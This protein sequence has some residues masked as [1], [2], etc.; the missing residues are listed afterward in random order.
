LFFALSLL[1]K[2]AAIIL[3][4]VLFLMDYW[5]D[6]KLSWKTFFEKIPF[7]VAA[8][9]FAFITLKIQTP[10]AV[11]GTDQYPLWTRPLFASYTMMIYFIRFF[12]PYPLAAFH[13]FPSPEHL[14]WPFFVAPFFMI[15]LLAF[16][17]VQRKNK[18]VVFGF[19]FFLINLLLVSQIISIGFTIVSERYTYVPYIGIAFML[20][21][22]L[23]QNKIRFSK[24]VFWAVLVVSVFVFG[25]MT[26]QRTKIWENSGNLWTD[27][28]KYYPNAPMPRTNRAGYY[29]VRAQT[30]GHEKEKD[31]LYK[32]AIEDCNIALKNKPEQSAAYEKRGLV[33]LE[34][35][36]NLEARS[37][38]DSL[39][40]YAPKNKLGYEIA[41]IARV[42]L[43]EP[44][45]AVEDFNKCLSF[46]P[47]YHRV[48][49]NRGD[50]L[51]TFYKKYNEALAD[52]NRAIE[53]SPLGDYYVSR[54]MC[55]YNLGNKEKAKEDAQAALQ[56]GAKL[57]ESF[58]KL[59][60][61]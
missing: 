41:G 53:L 55:Y 38:G 46:F 12:I 26:F 58:R 60:N 15:A 6:R 54:S 36:R 10:V 13:P 2:P 45:K 7:L 19:F 18:I 61:L 59:L 51:V 44:E 1:S 9:A 24:Q 43:N 20:G 29:S 52:Y 37:D 21:M 28:I 40:K 34:L 16:L 56:K 22:W 3:P 33:F 42:R 57:P 48:I 27:V 49:K 8:L 32:Q 31:S 50:L 35:G 39:Q 11:A 5:K 4:L 14:E 47:D 23:T 17:W 30:P 25:F